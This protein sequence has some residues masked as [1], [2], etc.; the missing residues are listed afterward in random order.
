MRKAMG[1]FTLLSLLVIPLG[2]YAAALQGASASVA[3]AL[4][5]IAVQQILTPQELAATVKPA[6]QLDYYFQSMNSGTSQGPLSQRI[7]TLSCRPCTTTCPP[8]EGACH[9]GP[10]P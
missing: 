5:S 9:P 2:A 4:D 6:V 10:C 3:P 7:C 1:L 8:G